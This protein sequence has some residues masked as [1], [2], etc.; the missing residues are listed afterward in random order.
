MAQSKPLDPVF[1]ELEMAVNKLSELAGRLEAVRSSH[2]SWVDSRHQGRML[3]ELP[4]RETVALSE[5]NTID[6]SSGQQ[7]L[8]PLM[9]PR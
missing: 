3:P 8:A 2:A 5:S 1:A 9:E 4:A 6:A 7:S